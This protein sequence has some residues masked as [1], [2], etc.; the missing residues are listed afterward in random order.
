VEYIY[1]IFDYLHRGRNLALKSEL[2]F[3]AHS[4]DRLHQVFVQ[5]S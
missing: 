3:S 2:N 4:Q 1:R 5:Q